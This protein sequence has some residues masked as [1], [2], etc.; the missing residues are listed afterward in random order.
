MPTNNEK[1]E[2]DTKTRALGSGAISVSLK[3]D[4][5]KRG[6]RT[7]GATAAK[8]FTLISSAKIIATKIRGRGSTIPLISLPTHNTRWTFMDAP[9]WIR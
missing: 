9:A 8:A 2:I 5:G 7:L 3:S 4:V 6:T 1:F